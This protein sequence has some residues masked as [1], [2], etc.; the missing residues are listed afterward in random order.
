MKMIVIYGNHG[1][2]K[3]YVGI[4]DCVPIHFERQPDRVCWYKFVG[5]RGFPVWHDLKADETFSVYK[6]HEE[7]GK[8]I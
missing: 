4:L 2:V 6:M 5:E 8:K 3:E 1:I 7:K